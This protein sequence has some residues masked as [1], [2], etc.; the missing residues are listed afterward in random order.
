MRWQEA[1]YC[2]RAPTTGWLMRKLD[3]MAEETGKMRRTRT[4]MKVEGS[5]RRIR[6]VSL[7]ISNAFMGGM[8]PISERSGRTRTMALESAVVNFC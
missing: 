6:I 1:T 7:K 5:E 3:N 8:E 4:D 2:V